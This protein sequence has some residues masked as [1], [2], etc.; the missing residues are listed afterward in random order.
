M[1]KKDE[2]TIQKMKLISQ[3]M[4]QQLP[5]ESEL[6]KMTLRYSVVLIIFVCVWT[7]ILNLILH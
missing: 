1:E 7:F 2:E 5:K 3:L 6:L 4:G